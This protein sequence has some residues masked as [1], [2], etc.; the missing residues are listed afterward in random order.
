MEPNP[1]PGAVPTDLPGSPRP[2]LSHSHT[3]VPSGADAF[4]AP[5]VASTPPDGARRSWRPQRLSAPVAAT[6]Y[7]QALPWPALPATHGGLAGVDPWE[8]RARSRGFAIWPWGLP[9]LVETLEVVALALLMFIAVRTVAQNFVV[10]GRSMEPTF[11]HGELVIVNKLSY[12]SF[13]LSWLPWVDS[14]NWRPFGEPAAGDV[15][16]FHFSRDLNRDFI[17]RIVAVAGQTVAVQDGLVY[18]DG[19]QLDESYIDEPPTYE[20][21]EQ[22]VPGGSV[23]VL[24]D[25]RNNS[26][27]SHSWGMLDESL[28]IGRTELRYWPLSSVGRIDHVRQADAPQ[29]AE[30]ST[31]PSIVR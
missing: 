12:D 18:V 5:Y 22:V 24:G 27:D 14:D 9:G 13:D 16:V 1:V 7:V 30:V 6:L 29:I 17:K 23:F 25:N 28:I 31:S 2:P 3:L 8:Q 10:D 26:F 15:V 4:A 20:L 21:A 19:V 11:A